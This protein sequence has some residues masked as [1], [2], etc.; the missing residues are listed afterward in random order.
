MNTI[1]STFWQI[2]IAFAYICAILNNKYTV[3]GKVIPSMLNFVSNEYYND[4]NISSYGLRCWVAVCRIF[5]LNYV[6]GY[7]CFRGYIAK[8][9]TLNNFLIHENFSFIHSH[10]I[11]LNANVLFCLSYLTKYKDE[12]CMNQTS[13]IRKGNPRKDHLLQCAQHT[14]PFQFTPF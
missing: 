9:C 11:K 3:V 10:R 14:Y 5:F 13:I 7:S 8:I 6:N 12:V 1:L 4:R 2:Y